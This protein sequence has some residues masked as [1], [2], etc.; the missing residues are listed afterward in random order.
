MKLTFVLLLACVVF[1]A[2]AG[3]LTK[4]E[5]VKCYSEASDKVKDE[6]DADLKDKITSTL[7]AIKGV[8]DNVKSLTDAQ[9]QRIVSHYFTGTCEP[10]KNFFQ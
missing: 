9:K 3:L 6:P 8:S 1:V 10:L 5:K 4:E 7:A 2:Q